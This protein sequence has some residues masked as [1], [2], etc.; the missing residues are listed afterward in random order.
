MQNSGE[1]LAIFNNNVANKFKESIWQ[2]TAEGD[3]KL[4]FDYNEESL[5]KL[6]SDTQL[7]AILDNSS[8][9]TM[10]MGS[11]VMT[12]KGIGR[13]IKL[14]NKNAT[15]KFLKED[16]E[17][18]FEESLISNDFP[19]FLRILDRDFSNWYRL[20]VPANGNIE[21]L[22]KIIE[23]LKLIDINNSNYTLIYNGMET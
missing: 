14:D 23:E 7:R 20:M 8:K 2:Q 5:G 1:N 11:L 4:F 12:P 22:K 17:E 15:V 3:W 13:L 21:A 18:I 10:K 9:K 6:E 16:I 19:I